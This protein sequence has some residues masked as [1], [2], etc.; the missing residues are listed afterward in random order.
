M[1]VT[2]KKFDQIFNEHTVL[3]SEND[4]LK[5]EIRLLREKLQYLIK[6][7]FGRSSER[8]NPEQLELAL[9]ELQALQVELELAEDQAEEEPQESKRGKRKPLDERIPAD[10]PVE[11][12]IIEPDEVKE[13]PELWEKIGEERSEQLD[14][15]PMRFFKIV[16]I[17]PKYKKIDDRSVAPIVAPAP[18]RLI[19]NSY[20][21]AGLILHI[22]LGKYCDHLPLYRQEQIFKQRFGVEISRK[23]MGGWMHLM[24][25]WLSLIY[26]A[27]RNE[28]RASGYIQADETFIKYQDPKK[29]YCP[30]GYLWAYH[31]PEVGVLYEWHP[32]RAAECLDSM[33]SDY[34]GLLQSDGY[35]GYTSWLNKPA[36]VTEKEQITHAACWAHARRKFVESYGHPVAE[37]IVKLIAKLYRIETNLRKQNKTDRRATRQAQAA[38]IL[39]QIKILLD[40]EQLRTLPKSAFGKAIN[41]T[42]ERWGM[43]N[44]YLEHPA[45]EIDN[46]L[47]ENAIR[48]TAIGKKNWLFFGSPNSGQDSAVLY[49]LIETCRKLSINPAEYLRDLF[50]SLPTM[51]QQ[52]ITSWTPAKWK[53]S[54]EAHAT[55][56]NA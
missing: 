50:E 27:L 14:V 47:V 24:A 4:Q 38:P 17:R 5:I 53:A 28:I 41:Y 19:E 51:N 52:E 6:K 18:K 30:N 23:T 34:R 40:T 39:Q 48:P 56:E 2:R 13:N 8:L 25:N 26:E 42:L 12:I 49:S 9:D 43:L 16:T 35:I 10:L 11:T 46:N 45:L 44:E 33:L 22:T 29:D 31:S 55:S 15:T 3:R 32:S 21:S 20:A 54:R 37:D 36:H 7:L 1:V